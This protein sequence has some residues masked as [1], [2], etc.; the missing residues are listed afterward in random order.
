MKHSI[1]RSSLTVLAAGAFTLF[2]VIATGTAH[3]A[4]PAHATA[5]PQA[6][7]CLTTFTDNEGHHLPTAKF[8][9]LVA[10]TTTWV[11]WAYCT[12][13]QVYQTADHIGWGSDSLT[14]PAG[15]VVSNA[16]ADIWPA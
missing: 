12:N 2:G 5:S 15:Y 7:F 4:E 10:S 13:G 9:C 8:T 11:G 3:A 14:C 16:G 6:E 1:R